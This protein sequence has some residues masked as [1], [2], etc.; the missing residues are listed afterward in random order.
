M[1]IILASGKYLKTSENSG[2]FLISFLR[3]SNFKDSFSAM[4]FSPS[5]SDIETTHLLFVN[6][7]KVLD[8]FLSMSRSDL[9]FNRTFMK[10]WEKETRWTLK[11]IAR[12]GKIKW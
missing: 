10:P 12:F 9:I 3:F 1:G 11:Y 7:S 5:S 4:V 6:F 2:L 8:K